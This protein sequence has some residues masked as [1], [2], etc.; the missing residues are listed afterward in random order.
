[1]N[2]AALQYQS[3]HEERSQDP[4][5]RRRRG[6]HSP[7]SSI[8]KG[9]TSTAQADLRVA[10]VRPLQ[11]EEPGESAHLRRELKAYGHFIALSCG[12]T[13]S[14]MN[15]DLLRVT[16]PFVIRPLP[17]V[18]SYIIINRSSIQLS[19]QAYAQEFDR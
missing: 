19:I 4:L 16:A 15:I 7:G 13:Q 10:D 17:N 11:L 14:F 3:K 9:H 6:A 1:M 18:V 8:C 2:D 12:R 5:I